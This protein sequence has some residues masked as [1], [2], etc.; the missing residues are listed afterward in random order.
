MPAQTELQ[1]ELNFTKEQGLTIQEK[2]LK[3][4]KSVLI[5]K[6]YELLEQEVKS[7]NDQAIDG[8]DVTRGDQITS[9]LI[10][11]VIPVFYSE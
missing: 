2:Q 10:N 5:L 4:F 1:K 7:S 3:E 8:F 6:A 9:I 11:N